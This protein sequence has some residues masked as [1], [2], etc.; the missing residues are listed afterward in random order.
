MIVTPAR[1]VCMNRRDALRRIAAA[2]AMSGVANPGMVMSATDDSAILSRKIPSS[3]EMLPAVGLGTWQT[4]DVGRSAA[5]RAPLEEVLREFVALGGRLLDSSPMYGA[6]EEVV[7]DL[8]SQL[9]LRN[10]L[11]VAT[12]VWTTGKQAG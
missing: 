5:E 2:A 6:S 1:D 12:K 3:G 7:G 11:F 4:F 9:G 8:S 10:K